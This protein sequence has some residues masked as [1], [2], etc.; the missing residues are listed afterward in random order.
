MPETMRLITQSFM[1]GFTAA[2]TLG[3]IAILCIQRTLKYGWRIGVASGFGVALADATYG[4][5][6]ALGL[7]VLNDLL[8][9]GQRLLGL[10]GGL[11][12]IMIGIRSFRS[13]GISPQES[14]TPAKKPPTAL[15][16]VVSILLLTLSNPVTIMFFSAVYAGLTVDGSGLADSVSAGFIFFAVGVFAGSLS[17]WMI[18]V[19]FVN[20]VRQRFNFNQLR[21]LNRVSGLLIAGFGVWVLVRQILA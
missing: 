15:G 12:L 20:A 4:L 7:K 5:V 19:S 2:A 11:V 14:S 16:A 3:P 8:I 21:W 18:L 6:G 17:W 1:I 9:S 13:S 10:A